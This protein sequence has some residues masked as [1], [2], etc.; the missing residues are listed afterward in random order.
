MVVA[1]MCRPLLPEPAPAPKARKIEVEEH[2]GP[3]RVGA[4]TTADQE[5]NLGMHVIHEILRNAEAAALGDGRMRLDLTPPEWRQVI[6][7]GQ[8]DEHR[9][10]PDLSE[11]GTRQVWSRMLDNAGGIAG[12]FERL[13]RD[14][15]VMP[16]RDSSGQRLAIA[17][18]GSDQPPRPIDVKLR[19]SNR[20]LVHIL[21]AED[22]EHK[23]VVRSLSL[24]IESPIA[25]LVRLHAAQ[26][27]DGIYDMDPRL[28][29]PQHYTAQFRKAIEVGGAGYMLW[30]LSCELLGL[31]VKDVTV[32]TVNGPNRGHYAQAVLLFHRLLHCP[33]L[34]GTNQCQPPCLA[35]CS[36]ISTSQ[37]RPGRLPASQQTES[38]RRATC[39]CCLHYTGAEVLAPVGIVFGATCERSVL[40]A[41]CEPGTWRPPSNT[42]GWCC[43]FIP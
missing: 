10:L 1:C 15:L 14:R 2:T 28:M 6:A 27:L 9:P 29:T 38:E 4:Y 35:T 7:A 31:H 12:V 32:E 42:R 34:Q 41:T 3:G 5:F 17:P 16:G 40:S 36:S 23:P 24:G 33:R 13:A 20:A 43:A 18:W 22:D 21:M 19:F 37:T 11:R 39:V 30:H 25:E 8:G 26:A